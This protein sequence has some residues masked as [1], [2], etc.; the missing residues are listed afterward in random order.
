MRRSADTAA[1]AQRA[2]GIVRGL[3]IARPLALPAIPRY[4]PSYIGIP[5]DI[6]GL[7]ASLSPFRV[8]PEALN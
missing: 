5:M 1:A 8:R 2:V 7:F 4:F 6:D 3:L